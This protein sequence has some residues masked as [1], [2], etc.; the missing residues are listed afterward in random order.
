MEM[1]GGGAWMR[2]EMP[3]GGAGWAGS[4]CSGMVLEEGGDAQGWWHTGRMLQHRDGG[5]LKVEAPG[6]GARRAG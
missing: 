2:M 4:G 5:W 6:D 1:A 3:R